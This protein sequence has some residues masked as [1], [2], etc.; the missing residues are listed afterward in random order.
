MKYFTEERVFSLVLLFATLII[1]L[2][3]IFFDFINFDDPA[4]IFIN[5]HV[6]TGFQWKNVEWAF[7]TFYIA[8]WHPLTW[9]SH[10]I[11]YFSFG[12][13]PAGH[14]ATNVIFHA[15]NTLLVFHFFNRAT[16][17]V[18]RSFIIAG[19]F[20]LHPLHVES[21]A[22][23]AERKD[24]LSAFFWFLTMIFH[25][26]Y[27]QTKRIKYYLF[28]I[29][30]FILGL[31]SKPMVVTLPFVL[32]LLEI[33]PLNRIK[34][35]KLSETLNQ[36]KSSFG[37]KIPF[38]IF[39]VISSAIT[40]LAQDRSGA[41]MNLDLLPFN[42]RF[43][44][45]IT[46]Y[47]EYLRKIFMPVDLAIQYPH[48]GND[49]DRVLIVCSIAILLSTSILAIRIIRSKPFFFAGWFWFLGTLIP[50]IGLVQVGS[51]SMA[52]RYT[53]IPALGIFIIMSFWGTNYKK[54]FTNIYVI[55]SSAFLV[56]MSLLTWNQLDYWRNTRAL[57]D[58]SAE[59]TKKNCVALSLLGQALSQE[60]K[61]DDA[62]TKCKLSIEI[63]PAFSEG[64]NALGSLYSQKNLDELADY[65]FRESIRLKPNLW[66]PYSNLG[67]ILAKKGKFKEAE[68]YMQMADNL[69]LS[70]RNSY[71]ETLLGLAWAKT[72]NLDKAIEHF[73]A[74]L[75][76]RPDVPHTLNNLG[77][78]FWDK[79]DFDSARYYLEKAL[80]LS[81]NSPDILNNYGL[82]LYSEKDFEG[83]I[84]YFSLALKIYPEYDKARNNLYKTISAILDKQKK[85]VYKTSHY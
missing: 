65:H 39:S 75:Q 67:Q 57:F 41:V 46:S 30:S 59:Y 27:V 51:Q 8:N 33:W 7:T 50:V 23:V 29:L 32:I 55:A 71:N 68:Y 18:W 73:H 81:P 53:Y 2:K 35:E 20:A 15:I 21:V 28:A 10:Y 84:Y 37:E 42:I 82:V 62:I 83:A 64:H 47:F 58:H 13:H 19:L 56:T 78:S 1:Y 72:R 69:S 4:Y 79:S 60:G 44:N 25:L 36:L 40:Y 54:A 14:H 31:L 63:N 22:W 48:Y 74:S 5:D 16:G 17:F 80:D 61:I 77:K 34:F 43:W 11:D 66:H 26:N 12:V 85:T 52:D 3:V 76:L 24:V 45:A 38:F 6:L 9:I 49:I 70:D